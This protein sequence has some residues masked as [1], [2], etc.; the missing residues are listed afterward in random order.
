MKVHEYQA[1]EILARYGVPVPRGRVATTPAEARAIATELG[2]PAV[3]KAQIHAGGRGKGGGIKLANTPAEAEAAAGQII[4]MTLVT[5]QTG[6]EGKLVHRVL[7]EEQTQIEREIYLAVLID[8]ST[9]RAILMGSAAGGMEIEEVSAS[10]P[11]S[12]KRVGVDPAAGFQP[13]LGREL[14]YELGLGGDLLRPAT[15]LMGNLHKAFMD[16]DCSLAEINPLVVTKDQRIIALDAKLSFDD[17]AAYKHPDIVALRDLDE[18]DPL[19]VRAQAEGV[20]NYVKLE[21]NIGCVV[22]GAG[23]AMATMDAIAYAGGQPA[24]FLDIGTV[25]DPER[26]VNALGII[27]TD[28]AVK[29]VLINIYGGMARVDVIAQGIIDA[30]AK[31][32]LTVPIV[33]RLAGTNLE[34]GVKLLESSSVHVERADDL[35][36]AARKAV[37]AAGR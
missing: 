14:A 34:E 8:Q 23:L 3:V 20:N 27:T 4:G 6:P 19:E 31:L 18:E 25:N 32:S 5:P 15:A 36:E 17:N 26:V 22:N 37:A 7:V 12:I 28:P 13:Y 24:N 33:A 2:V 29:A 35:G 9:S 11:E 21:G 30:N 1:K 10:H 16:T